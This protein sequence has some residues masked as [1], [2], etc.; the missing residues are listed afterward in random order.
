VQETEQST[1]TND[2]DVQAKYELLKKRDE[3]MTAFMTNFEKTR[4]SIVGEQQSSRDV[5]VALLEHIGRGMD[6]STNMPSRE[7]HGEMEEAKAF[8]EKNLATAQVRRALSRP[9][10]GPLSVLI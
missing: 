7:A 1:G 3:E 10:S 4:E 2:E 6:E 5:I 9:L 8:K